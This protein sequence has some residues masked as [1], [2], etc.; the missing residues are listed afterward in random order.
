[1]KKTV[2]LCSLIAAALF[3]KF[4]AATA[5]VIT[6]FYPSNTLT[7]AGDSSILTFNVTGAEHL[8]L[9]TPYGRFETTD[10]T[11]P[12]TIT[13]SACHIL[14][15]YWY[16]TITF[17][18]TAK[19]SD[20]DTSNATLSIQMINCDTPSFVS[21]GV[22]HDTVCVGDSATAWWNPRDEVHQYLIVGTDTTIDY[23]DS[24]Y[25]F[26]RITPGYMSIKVILIG[27]IS[28]DPHV[29]CDGDTVWITPKVYFKS[30]SPTDVPETHATIS[31]V[32]V[33]PVPA[34]DALTIESDASLGRTI[35]LV[36]VHGR[37]VQTLEINGSAQ[38]A[39]LSVSNLPPGVYVLKG[40]SFTKTITVVR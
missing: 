15:P 31:T 40:D 22:E 38:K 17:T 32:N 10:P 1:M 33:Y 34:N 21:Y 25:R 37:T 2:L 5:P 16:A 11:A 8:Y 7:C 14:L 35:R 20:G 24:F 39:L 29:P 27:T 18:L 30:C 6:S 28:T 13:G 12:F 23:N 4:A 19:A 3:P 9:T 36:D 26:T